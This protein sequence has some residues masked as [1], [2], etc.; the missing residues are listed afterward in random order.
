MKSNKLISIIIPCYNDWQYIEQAVASALNQTYNNI[1]VIIVDDGSDTKTKKVLSTLK[2]KVDKIITQENQGV[3]VARNVGIEEAKGDLILVLDS[4]DYFEPDFLALAY[5][6]I[7]ENDSIALIT[8]WSNV[9]NSCGDLLYVTHPT[10]SDSNEILYYNNAMGSCL[11]KKEVWRQVGGYDLQMKSGYEDWE[12]NISIAKKGYKIHVLERILFNYRLT[13]NSRNTKAIA[14]QKNIRKYVFSKHKDLAMKN[15]EK[16]LNFF[17]D[18]I[19]KSKI[20]ALR[21]KTSNSYMLGHF[22]FRNLNKIFRN[23]K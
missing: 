12:F 6:K 2:A 5:R 16:T 18:E 13:K 19:E 10:G 8:C 22:F 4:D 17:L 20:E 11:F 3:C 21:Y 7:I 1:E 14:F 23:F 9:V 15:Y